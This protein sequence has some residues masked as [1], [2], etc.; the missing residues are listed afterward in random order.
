M[1]NLVDLTDKNIIITGASS[2][3]GRE[4]AYLL[5]KLGAN[6]I[7]IAR[8][9]EK[10][11]EI[12]DE[13]GCRAAAYSFDLSELDKISTEIKRIVSECGQ[14]DGLVHCAGIGTVRPLKML[15]PAALNE[16]MTVNYYSFVEIV[17]CVTAKKIFNPGLSIVG[18][19]S[20]SSV[21][22]NQSKTAYC[23]SKAAMDASVRCMAK[24]L[25]DK[26]V[27]VNTIAPA[28]INT[29]IYK[30]FKSS[31]T[32]SEDAKIIESRQYMGVGEPIDVANAAAFLLSDAAKYITGIMLL[33]DG[34][35]FT[36]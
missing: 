31:G 17:R 35:R 5:H 18:I 12:K 33:M 15:K 13:L 21:Q 34:G 30:E 28:L 29:E 6:V 32:D 25:A 23:A 19:S 20:V 9:A 26:S 14:I 16:V 7:L 22:G 10:L 3:I 4:T 24:E 1:Y 36:S 2:G 27:R 11:Q 8:R